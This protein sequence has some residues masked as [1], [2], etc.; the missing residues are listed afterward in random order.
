MPDFLS[1]A[2][3][4]GNAPEHALGWRGIGWCEVFILPMPKQCG[5]DCTIQLITEQQRE[6]TGRTN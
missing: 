1:G 5:G 3:K 6:V 4:Q 2:D